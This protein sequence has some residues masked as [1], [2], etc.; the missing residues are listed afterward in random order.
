MAEKTYYYAVKKGRK[1]GI[2][3]SWEEC[4]KQVAGFSG[5]IFRKFNTVEAAEEFLVAEI[6]A[7]SRDDNVVVDKMVFQ[8]PKLMISNFD[9]NNNYPVDKWNI[10]DDEFYIFI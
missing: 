5:P 3:Q 2:F 8:I 6:P 10:Y 1:T 7:L 4:S 9:I